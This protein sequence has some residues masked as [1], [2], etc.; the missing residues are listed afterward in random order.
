MAKRLRRREIRATCGGEQACA[1]HTIGEG[2]NVA[3]THSRWPPHCLLAGE[4][5]PPGGL[6]CVATCSAGGSSLAWRVCRD[7]EGGAS[8]YRVCVRLL[9]TTGCAP[10][11]PPSGA[12]CGRRGRVRPNTRCRAD[13]TGTFKYEKK[14]GGLPHVCTYMSA[15]FDVL[16]C[17]C[18]LQP[19]RPQGRSASAKDILHSAPRVRCQ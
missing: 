15:A 14:A 4:A 18:G 19:P 3:R 9:C 16:A 13:T 1:I 5:E 7:D 12:S 11:P 8:L 17:V 10:P 2:G 6:H